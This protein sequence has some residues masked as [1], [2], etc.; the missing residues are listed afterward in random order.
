MFKKITFEKKLGID[1]TDKKWRGLK[2]CTV[3]FFMAFFGFVL[4][5]LSLREIGYWV[6][7]VGVLVGFIG[8]AIH[9]REMFWTSKILER[10]KD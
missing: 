4:V 1:S 8:M 5:F 9:F 3:S 6:L 2:I 7:V 10:M